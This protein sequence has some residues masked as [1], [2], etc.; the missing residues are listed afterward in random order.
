MVWTLPHFDRDQAILDHGARISLPQRPPVHLHGTRVD[1][2]TAHD[3]NH[4]RR[5]CAARQEL[6]KPLGQKVEQRIARVDQIVAEL[7]DM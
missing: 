6:H 3:I 1:Q 7:L 2:A 4:H 5:R